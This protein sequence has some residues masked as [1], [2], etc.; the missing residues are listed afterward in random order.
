MKT[1]KEVRNKILCESLDI[2]HDLISI[3]GYTG[4]KHIADI[5]ACDGLSSIKYCM[6]FPGSTCVA[7]E[8]RKDNCIKIQENVSDFSLEKRIFIVNSALGEYHTENMKYYESFGQAEGVKDWDTGDKSSSILSPKAHIKEHPWC[9]F[10]ESHCIMD[11]LDNI[12]IPKDFLPF[13]FLHIDVQGAEIKVINGAKKTI[14]KAEAIWIEVATIELYRGQPL[15]NTIERTM[16][17]LGFKLI[18]DTC[19]WKYGDQLWSR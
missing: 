16:K 6:T 18:K 9:K 17:S 7:F 5:G 1:S 19:Q 14:S 12:S 10:K 4:P 15:K 2:Q 13:D 3:F 11:K 8:M